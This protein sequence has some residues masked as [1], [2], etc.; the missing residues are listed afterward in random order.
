MC[1]PYAE[2]VRRALP[3]A[4]WSFALIGALRRPQVCSAA[5]LAALPQTRLQAG[6]YC[7]GGAHDARQYRAGWWQGAALAPLLQAAD[8][9]QAA[10]GV[11]VAADGARVALPLSWL[12]RGLLA[13][14]FAGQ[15]LAAEDGA[16]ARLIVPGLSACMNLRWIERIELR[17]QPAP[18]PLLARSFT[19]LSAQTDGDG[20]WL[21]GTAFC[22]AEGL[23]AVALR[24]DDGPSLTLPVQAPPLHF[25]RWSVRWTPP[26]LGRWRIDAAIVDDAG[27]EL[28][29]PAS[30]S[31]F[32]QAAHSRAIVEVM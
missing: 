10:A 15:P 18:E 28:A 23:S 21:S 20:C 13:T 16:P 26:G 12:R 2:G 27:L 24:V 31:V 14:H 11:L 30:S 9:A 32:A 7:A 6:M 5:D 1:R 29:E 8:C 17:T 22:G 25:A 4:Y 19:T 3:S